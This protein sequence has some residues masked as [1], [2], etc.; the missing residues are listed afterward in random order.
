M[1][2]YDRKMARLRERAARE[3]RMDTKKSERPI[4]TL[5]R[6][7]Y[8]HCPHKRI[9]VESDVAVRSL[10]M[11]WGSIIDAARNYGVSTKT[12]QSEMARRGITLSSV[13]DWTPE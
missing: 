5:S 10:L 7:S 11:R 9:R 1:S 3:A 4:G 2:D 13:L 12:L 8:A 6:L